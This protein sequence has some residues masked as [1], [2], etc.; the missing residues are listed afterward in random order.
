MSESP[1]GKKAKLRSPIVTV[2]GHID[3]GKTSL[4]DKMRGTGVQVREAAG[5]TQ[6]I[7]A[8]FFPTET[9][10]KICGDLL[11]S[12]KTELTIDGLLFI[13]TP[14]HEAYL[15]LRRRGGAIADIAILV[16]DIN[17]GALTQT[18]ESLKI[19]QSG[20]TPFLVVANKLDKVPG[21]KE[22]PG[23]PLVQAMKTQSKAVQAEIDRRIYEI[24]GSLSANNFNSERFDRVRDFKNT[25]AIVPTSAKTGE[26]IPE[27][28]M[29]LSGLTQQY[30]KD[31]LRV[32]TGPAR[33]AILEV[34]EETGLGL[35]LDTIIYEGT[36]RKTDTIVIGGLE[37]DIVA[38]IRTLLQP[39][40]LDEIRDPKEKFN[41]VSEVHAAAG[42]KIVAP[43]IT[44]AVA[45]APVYAVSDLEKLEEVRQK[46]RD[47]VSAI[48]IH[49]DSAG[50]VVKADTLGSL[51]AVTTF[52]QDR[53]V[54]VRVADV[55]PIVKR[56]V[57]E[58]FATGDTDP[59]NA[60]I[61]GFNV[62]FAPD[63]EDLAAEY[64][65]EVF[66]SD[67][68]YR[69]Y[70]EY[71]AWQIVKSE[72][73]KAESLGAIIR[74]GKLEL[75]PDYVFRHKNPAIVGVRVGGRITP[76]VGLINSEGKR[77]GMILQIQDRSVNI[78][79][80][81]D[82]M[83]VAVSIRGPTIGRQVK[84]DETLYVD[85]PDSHIHA[86]RKK[87]QEDLSPPE[88]EVLKEIIQIKRDAGAFV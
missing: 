73:A 47:E 54:P 20:K 63:I 58:A 45:G 19:L 30:M 75:I 23:M 46:V 62:K 61:L 87:F 80:A 66:L 3:H 71:N 72:Q 11:K 7:G 24:V 21:W 56:D 81:T 38:K 12:V 53:K 27:L 9:I 22:I 65:V 41:P 18:Y 59:I 69:L 70:D 67:V 83:E 16:I 14:G 79:E 1:T 37:G 82:G 29:V 49:R 31:R 88:R 85:V 42:V 76:R 55:G 17:E 10:L 40:E 64:G 2:L 5:I 86:I 25:V 52:L 60:V 39:K 84:E 50:I 35:T 68:I 34:R 26:G 28:L 51:E 6:H 77:V 78:D 36:L 44:G 33:G 15:N 48:R 4:L 57:L 32:V 13:D 74:P 43:D 8:S